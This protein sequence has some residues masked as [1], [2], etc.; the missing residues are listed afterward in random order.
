[1]AFDEGD[2]SCGALGHVHASYATPCACSG[3]RSRS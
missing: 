2:V 1:M 3:D